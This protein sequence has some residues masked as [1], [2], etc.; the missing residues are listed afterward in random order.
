MRRGLP[1]AVVVF[2]A[3]GVP[4]GSAVAEWPTKPVRIVVPYAAGGAADMLGRVFAE[5]FG[6]ALGQ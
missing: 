5:R 3:L 1:R 2:L 4:V 6:E